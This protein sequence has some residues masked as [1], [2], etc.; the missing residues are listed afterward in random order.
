MLLNLLVAY[1]KFAHLSDQEI[2]TPLDVVKVIEDKKCE[3][4]AT[5]MSIIFAL[6]S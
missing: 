4:V 3:D 1:T 5:Y 6:F 2:C